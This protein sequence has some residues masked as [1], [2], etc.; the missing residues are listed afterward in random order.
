MHTEMRST[1]MINFVGDFYSAPIAAISIMTKIPMQFTGIPKD[2][3]SVTDHKT[4]KL[5]TLVHIYFLN[6]LTY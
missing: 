5:R 1:I 3:V 4:G 2:R 6:Q